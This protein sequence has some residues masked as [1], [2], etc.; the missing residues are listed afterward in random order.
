MATS[1]YDVNVQLTLAT[2]AQLEGD[3]PNALGFLAEAR[4][5]SRDTDRFTRMRVFVESARLAYAMRFGALIPA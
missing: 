2:T 4:R 3:V 5:L 1:T